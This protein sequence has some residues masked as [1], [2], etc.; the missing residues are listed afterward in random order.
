MARGMMAFFSRVGV[1][2]A[3]GYAA[4]T[5]L[6]VASWIVAALAMSTAHGSFQRT[7]TNLDGLTDQVF[8]VENSMLDQETG[9]RGYLV[10]RNSLFLQP[11]A[12]GRRAL[13]LAFRNAEK[14]AVSP[15]E[16]QLLRSMRQRVA[17]WEKYA[18]SELTLLRQRK[19][20]EAIRNE[21]SQTGKRLF[22]RFRR[23]VDA[24]LSYERAQR[25]QELQTS[26]STFNKANWILTVILAMAAVLVVL[27][28]WRLTRSI[29]RPL[30]NLR[31][32]ARRIRQGH[33][34]I[35][36]PH[37]GRDELALLGTDMESMRGHLETRRE[38]ANLVAS[39]L[40]L[41]DIF[42]PFS[43]GVAN[44][45]RFDRL[46]INVVE[47]SG[48]EMKT[49]YAQGSVTDKIMTG[50]RRP[51]SETVTS[52]TYRSGEPVIR[53]DLNE[54][55]DE[56]LFTDELMGRDGGIRSF[57]CVPLL[58]KGRVVGTLNVS[59]ETRAAYDQTAVSTLMTLSQPLANA[60]ENAHLYREISHANI[61]LEQASKMKSEF[62]AN[63]SHELRTP[64]N[65][66]IGFSEVLQDGT[67]GSLNDRQERYV[68]NVLGSGKHLLGLV[69]DILDISKVE[70]GR[71]DLHLEELNVESL[72][73]Q[74]HATMLPVAQKKGVR[75]QLGASAQRSMVRAD[76]SRFIQI[77]YNL[78]SNAIKFT[79]SEGSVMVST[80]CENEMITIA[81]TDTGIGIDPADQDRIF[82]EFEQVDSAAARGQEGTGLG[83][84]LTRRLIALH[85][86]TLQVQSA[87]GEG[88]TFTVSLPRAEISVPT[89][90]QNGTVLVV[91]D[92]P[93]ARELLSV[94]LSE[95]G[96]GVEW[97]DS[98]SEVIPRAREVNPVAITLDI[99]LKS[100]L[101]WS[102]LKRLKSDPETR[103]IP[104]II[105]SILD[106]RPT[107]FALGASA[108]ITK[109][110][111]K[112]GLLGAI[113][114]A[115]H[116]GE[117]IPNGK[118]RVL[119]VD[120]EPKSLEL[121]SLA[122][123][124]TGYGF[125]SATDGSTGLEL[126]VSEE[127]DVLIVDLMMKPMSG[128]D[129]ISAARRD[130]RTR[131]I[132][133]VVLTACD[134]TEEDVHRLNRDVTSIFSKHGLHNGHFLAELRRVTAGKGV[135]GVC[136]A[137]S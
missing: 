80:K 105:V 136:N 94:Y 61:E 71:M 76:R 33:T 27:L 79:P 98:A 49:A 48:A 120:D 83:L 114:H 116:Q 122:L 25:N 32:A 102:A 23:T 137:A 38:L 127:P 84:A 95:A 3:S 43:A 86:G 128:F 6:L 58:T 74:V 112:A 66:I 69:N 13:P 82:E 42:A 117:T 39:S 30:R 92:E 50:F 78:L 97:V 21:K 29:V 60:V 121:I 77:M 22:D 16:F 41:E 88:S 108:W 75:L 45:V 26:Q 44:L 119:A 115:L 57:V 55:S 1:R 123:R 28:A 59:S 135:E 15:N 9:L 100:E 104:V 129:L 8:V 124:G 19:Q 109:P 101:S 70:A 111:S 99:K 85:G 36:V 65:A 72:L 126:L 62:L 81:V 35:P 10:G 14:L 31:T 96:Y 106:E 89:H 68:G 103:D 134:L 87:P 52:L 17:A 53:T 118:L 34:D 20:A 130:S 67:F 131:H 7:V 56:Q 63:M 54:L 24:T 11:Y 46:S 125:L 91:E 90:G 113:G 37:E 2:L 93:P 51:M 110:V 64:L 132:P 107:G 18:S 73:P 5:V 40:E 12:Q 4:V 47:N 133:I